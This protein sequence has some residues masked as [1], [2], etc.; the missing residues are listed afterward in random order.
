VRPQ[1]PVLA[2][3]AVL[4]IPPSVALGEDAAAT[5]TT[6]TSSTPASTTAE[7]APATQTPAAPATTEAAPA[8]TTEAPS[9]VPVAPAA[10][11]TTTTAPPPTTTPESSATDGTTGVGQADQSFEVNATPAER[12]RA[13]ARKAAA[14]RRA[15]AKAKARAEKADGADADETDDDA[16]AD[17]DA[18]D[19]KA[20]P[21]DDLLGAP[22]TGIS[23]LSV[24]RFRIPP[25]LL[26]I[27]QAAGVQYG[28][29]WEVLAA[30]NEIETDYG[31]NLNVSTAGAQGWMQFMPPTWATY[32][33]DANADGDQDPYN[34]V[35]AIF[36]AARYL[37]AAGGDQDI[38]T[39]VFAY[40]HADWYVDDVLKRA[41]SIAALPADVV[42][43]LT[44]LTLAQ[45]PV[46]SPGPKGRDDVGVRV[47]GTDDP[48]WAAISAPDDAAVVAVQDATVTR[49]GTSDKLGR[50]VEL[51]DAYGNR[52]TYAHLGRLAED[53]VVARRATTKAKAKDEDTHE[54]AE[55]S[56]DSGA[57]TAAERAA[58][59]TA[60]P[61]D[62]TVAVGGAPATSDPRPAAPAT[63]GTQVGKQQANGSAD[64]ASSGTTSS[65][66]AAA[67]TA[68]AAARAGETVE[69]SATTGGPS[70]G[71]ARPRT[72]LDDAGATSARR[73]APTG[74]DPSLAGTIP[75]PAAT[76]PTVPTD[77]TGTGAPLPSPE[78]RPPAGTT[79]APAGTT[80]APGETTT[81]PAG[82]TTAPGEAPAGTS[83]TP[84]AGV[85]PGAGAAPHPVVPTTVL[86]EGLDGTIGAAVARIVT[87]AAEQVR[88]ALRPVPDSAVAPEI[89]KP[90]AKA[91][92]EDVDRLD[93][94][95]V[96]S[97]GLRRADVRRRPLKVGSHVLAGSVLGRTGSTAM[98][99]A[100][101]PAGTGAPRIDPRPIV[102]GWRLLDDARVFSDDD[103]GE[104]V[105]DAAEKPGVGRLLLMSKEQLQARVLADDRLTI[106][107][108]GREDI[109]TGQIDR[110]V[111]ATMEYLVAN[112]HRLTISSLKSGHSI[113]SASG[114]VSAHSYGA[115]FDIAAVDGIPI[116][117]HQGAGSIT[118]KTIRL[119]LRLQGTSKPNQIISLMT[120]PGTDNTL[121][122]GDHDDH[123]HV[124]FPKEPGVDGG[125]ARLGAQVA[126]VL[127]PAQWDQLVDRLAD[128][129]NPTVRRGVSAAATPGSTAN[130][131][132]KAGKKR[133][134]SE[135]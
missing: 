81:A 80:T 67:R 127:K 97:G 6:A 4:A 46:H 35:D 103:R 118:D 94:Y 110:R 66:K 39:A 34:P 104:L 63:A 14:A 85:L 114:N 78:A 57:T 108:A 100:I 117:G 71:P 32:G 20:T 55:A 15:A 31:R 2:V 29:R 84:S 91:A 135:G 126:A 112:G 11:A 87:V 90:R 99:F 65:A 119:M 30:I 109:R 107:P 123:I 7:S 22:A 42:S 1:I 61:D 105:A 3:L 10:P 74:N 64:K 38:R 95:I 12:R 92:D 125:N 98:R 9:A 40:N 13:R 121:A 25:F 19:A 130:E 131:G 43:S 82:T 75:A 62:L 16:K 21:G 96:R 27:Y 59:T 56:A 113:L 36:A 120:Y 47:R 49:I 18:E 129:D 54:D 133:R 116:T 58:A 128:I 106:Y 44:G 26:P 73:T 48:D 89:A 5:T 77:A 124:G 102:A 79:T 52:Y 41:R 45:V 70:I 88:V 51:R 76:T 53:H 17:D 122:M 111:L 23:S 101:R 115:A 72:V 83:T 8:P 28:I 60:A 50:Y 132:K 86:P 69:R 68:A 37:R 33:V 93:R 24:A 134:G